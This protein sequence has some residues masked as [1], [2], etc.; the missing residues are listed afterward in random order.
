MR[1]PTPKKH[2]PTRLV[3]VPYW[4]MENDSNPPDEPALPAVTGA[5][6]IDANGFDPADYQWVPVLRRPRKDGWTPQRQT[7]FIA[8]LADCGVVE[9]AANAV[10]MSVTS[11]YRLRR[12][13]GAGNF[14]AAWDAAIQYASKRL[15]DLAFDRAINGSDEP[16]FDR[17]GC[18]VGRQMKTN[19]RLLM[20]L[21]RAYMPDRFR[22][23]DPDPRRIDHEPPLELAPVSEALA[24]LE[25]VAPDE[26]ALLLAPDDLDEAYDI[27]DLLQGE[28]AHWHRGKG[29]REPYVETP[30]EAAFAK[31]F[32]EELE[33]AMKAQAAGVPYVPRAPKREE[34]DLD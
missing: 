10:N 7:E 14:A 5:S 4:F 19:D 8:A 20:F 29:D 32:D 16:V 28:I 2:F 1:S 30:A 11:C 12:A 31:M 34:R 24:R 3:Y 33:R 25:P 13:P 18:R 22:S 15:L 17:D 26:P 6:E 21:L 23:T 9:Q 27:A